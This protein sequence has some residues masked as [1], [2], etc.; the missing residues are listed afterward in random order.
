M[1]GVKA[2]LDRLQRV[3]EYICYGLVGAMVIVVFAQVVCRFVLRASL[4]WSEEM[5]RYMMVWISMLGASIGLRQGAHIGVEAMVLL[6][7]VPLK[8][9]ATLLGHAVA[10]LFSV[11]LVYYGWVLLQ[12]VAHQE[13]PAMEVSMAIPYGALVVGGILMGLYSLE[14]LWIAVQ[15]MIRRE[16]VAS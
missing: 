7:P 8:K 9:C 4:P 13:S 6:L 11:W 10:V 5:S 1:K 2:V 12:I 14:S 3:T 16:E 15:S